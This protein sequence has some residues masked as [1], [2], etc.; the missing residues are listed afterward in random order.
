MMWYK[1]VIASIDVLSANVI[2]IDLDDTQ[3]AA[4]PFKSIAVPDLQLKSNVMK[5]FALA[6][7]TTDGAQ[8]LTSIGLN[9]KTEQDKS[10]ILT[11]QGNWF[12]AS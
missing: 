3:G 9:L 10:F 6:V 5:K 7:E 4:S 1:M 12:M 11:L 2:E 8:A